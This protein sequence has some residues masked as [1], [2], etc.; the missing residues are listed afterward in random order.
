MNQRIMLTKKLLKTGL[1]NMLQTQNIYQ[2]SIR[3]LCE[4]AGINRSTFYK[5]YG[6]QFDL[7]SEMEQDLLVSIESVLTSQDDYSKNAIEQILIY[8]END[9]EFVRLLLNSNVDPEFP[10]KLFSLPP[11]LRMLNELMANVPEE[12]S[13]YYY[14]FLLSGAY[15]I[16]RTWVNKED[17]EKTEWLAALLFRMIMTPKEKNLL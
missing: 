1:T 3:E 8:L 16:V 6:S 9:I 15:E 10:K 12:E 14:R 13:D 4:N 5:Y 17:R 2:I 11:I 7:L